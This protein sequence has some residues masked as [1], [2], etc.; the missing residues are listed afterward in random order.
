MGRVEAPAHA[1][2][3]LKVIASN[4]AAS[5]AL[6]ASWR[7]SGALHAL[8]PASR[9]PS[10]RLPEDEIAR[11]RERMGSWLF[12]AQASIDR[13]F[14]AVGG[15]RCSVVLADPNGVIL[16]R[17]GTPCD[18]RLFDSSGLWTGVVWSEKYEGTN[19][20][21]TCI[22]EQRAVAIDRDQHFFT[23]N[24]GLFCTTAPIFD[25]HGDLAAALD[26]SSWRGDLTDG[27][28]R[29]IGSAVADAARFIEA[30]NFR[31]A[32]PKARILLAPTS[33]RYG[34]SLLAVDRDDLVI[35][36]T[37]AARLGLGVN[38]A[39]LA[40]P[41]PAADLIGHAS[42]EGDDINAAERAVLQRALARSSGKRVQGG[43]G[44]QHVARHIPPEDEGAPPTRP[45]NPRARCR[46]S[47]TLPSFPPCGGLPS[48]KRERETS[49]STPFFEQRHSREEAHDQS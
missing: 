36:A 42:A 31:R 30:E 19:G 34:S 5:S 48:A 35:G 33:E 41:T 1:D 38:S 24:S 16:D 9:A 44:P 37:R 17:R 12:A 18:D 20:I 28:A 11:S 45:M 8:D 15:V 47:E 10:Q 43:E 7:R 32:F 2:Y 14:L 21:G 27:F 49:R 4:D 3:V 39:S 23:R 25:E 6:A 13:L 40:R 46:K 22:V 29:L 26:V